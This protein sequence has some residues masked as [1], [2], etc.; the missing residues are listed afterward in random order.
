MSSLIFPITYEPNPPWAWEAE[1]N[2]LRS[3]NEDG[4]VATRPR[5]TRA[6]DSLTDVT[7]NLSGT[8]AETVQNFYKVTTYNGSLPFTLTLTTPFLTISKEVYFSKPPTHKYI[9]IGAF[10]TTCSFMEV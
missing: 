3:P 9:G 10:E 4:F 7:W 6:R 8:D 2:T 1:D 5:Y